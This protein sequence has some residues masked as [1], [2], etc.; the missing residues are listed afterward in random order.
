MK[1]RNSISLPII[2]SAVFYRHKETI[3]FSISN[4]FLRI[5]SAFNNSIIPFLKWRAVKKKV[6]GARVAEN[7][8]IFVGNKYHLQ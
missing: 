2:A 3:I 8:A 6:A 1:Y 5:Y 4:D 7:F